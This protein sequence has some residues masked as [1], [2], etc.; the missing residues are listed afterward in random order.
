MQRD[1]M[2][3]YALRLPKDLKTRYPIH[4]IKLATIVFDMFI[5][6]TVITFN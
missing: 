3:T 1:K 5:L 6:Y 4:D 2:I